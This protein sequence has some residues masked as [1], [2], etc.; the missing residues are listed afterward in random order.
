VLTG[1]TVSLD[2]AGMMPVSDV[3]YV[4]GSGAPYT[5]NGIVPEPGSMLLI[6]SGLVAALFAR[7]VHRL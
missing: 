6:G 3:T 4:S 2:S 5:V 1:L 7:R